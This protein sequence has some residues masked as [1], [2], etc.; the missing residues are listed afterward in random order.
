MGLFS[1][2]EKRQKSRTMILCPHCGG[3]DL[4]FEAGLITGYKY[5]CKHCDYVGA[6]I[7]EKEVDEFIE[8]GS[9]EDSNGEDDEKDG[10]YGEVDGGDGPDP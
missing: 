5:H 1:R 10:K 4:Y 2:K 8:E 6:F 9:G 7:I 3:S